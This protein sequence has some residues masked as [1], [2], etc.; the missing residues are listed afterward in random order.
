MKKILLTF[1][2]ISTLSSYHISEAA[3]PSCLIED[4][5]APILSEYIKNNRIIIKNISK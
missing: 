3:D 4:A 1:L 5:P 2:V